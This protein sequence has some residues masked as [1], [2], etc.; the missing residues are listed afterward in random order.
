MTHP[1]H[2]KK[3]YLF[4]ITAFILQPLSAILSNIFYP[5]DFSQEFPV[6]DPDSMMV[7]V[8]GGSFGIAGL[9][10]LGIKLADEK[11]VI[12]AAGFTMLAI[13]CGILVTSVFEISQ[14]VSYESY[15]KF[16]RIQTSGNFLYLPGMYLVTFYDEFKKWI[17]YIGLLSSITLITA[18]ILFLTGCRD[19]KLLETI[20][21][22]GFMIF[23][24]TFFS[25]AYNIYLI[26]RKNA[27]HHHLK[28]NEEL[29]DK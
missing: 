5:P 12:P 1:A 9:T 25:W 21:N 4:I 14:V 26:Y 8:I 6:Y 2:E 15:E 20:S 28:T 24:I 7:W 27:L 22:L 18:S 29:N 23:F 13:S 10:L 11:K 17:R 3:I 19:F 16:Y